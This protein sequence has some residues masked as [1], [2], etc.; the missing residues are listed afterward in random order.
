LLSTVSFSSILSFSLG[1]FSSILSF[2]SV[3]CAIVVSF[4]LEDFLANLFFA[5][6]G[7]KFSA[8]ATIAL[9]LTSAR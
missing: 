3:A 8:A 6:L 1:A 4:S 9:S 5:A 7:S 2:S